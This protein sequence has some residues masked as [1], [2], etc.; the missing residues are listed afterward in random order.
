MPIVYIY[1]L[2]EGEKCLSSRSWERLEKINNSKEYTN[3]LKHIS[4]NPKY[5]Q[6]NQLYFHAADKIQFEKYGFLKSRLLTYPLSLSNDKNIFV[7]N[8]YITTYNTFTYIF[9]KLKKGIYVVIKNN[10]LS[11][12]YHLI[13]L[14]ILII[15][16]KY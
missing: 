1:N 5:E 15:G 8:N 14:I 11:D 3:Y 16:L 7:G 12:I 4:T 6:F 13:I 10:K 2:D 9:D